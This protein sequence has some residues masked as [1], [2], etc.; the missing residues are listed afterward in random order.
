MIASKLYDVY[1]KRIEYLNKKLSSGFFNLTESLNT[2]SGTTPKKTVLSRDRWTLYRY[3]PVVEKPV[4]IPIVIIYALVNRYY[5]M[6]L[7]PDRSMVKKFLETGLDVYV[8]DWGYP[9]PMDKYLTL[10]DYINDYMNE[11]IDY[12]CEQSKTKS[13]NLFG[14][15]Q[16]GT[17]CTIYTALYPE[18]IK[19]LTLLVAPVDFDTTNGLLN[20]WSHYM[21]IDKMVD[22]LGNISGDLMNIGFL[23][24]NPLRLMFG[25]YVDF[26]DNIDD[27]NFVSNFIR[28]E[29]WIFDSPDLAG[30]TF[31]KFIKE[32]YQENRLVK[33]TFTIGDRTVDLKKI[34]MPV[35]N[36]FA[37][38]DHLVP[39]D[40][41]R[42]LIDLISS[43]DK[44][45]TSFRTGHIGIFTSSKSQKEYAP[46]IAQ[47]IF[48]R[49]H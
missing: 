39:P 41:S 22:T 31:R 25:K 28:M 17:F 6:D 47:W 35:H 20:V 37:E 42:P 4:G 2:E 43:T 9:K 1:L 27:K 24:L 44:T 18:K 40:S 29:K 8:L 15:C 23:M 46:K 33:G 7:Q 49:S 48:D 12:V 10:E 14:V 3:D 36:V 30:E 45:N 21:D 19:N 34:N 11:I 38:L 13:V 5:M 16:G 26:I 32:L